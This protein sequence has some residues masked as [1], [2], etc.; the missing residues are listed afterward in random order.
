VHRAMTQKSLLFIV[1]NTKEQRFELHARHRLRN[2]VEVIPFADIASVG[3]HCT[4]ISDEDG[5]HFIFHLQLALKSGRLVQ[6][7]DK[8]EPEGQCRARVRRIAEVT[9]LPIK[10]DGDPR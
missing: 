5:S 9:D 10:D 1:A 7:S 3:T 4:E 2:V 6:L 8:D